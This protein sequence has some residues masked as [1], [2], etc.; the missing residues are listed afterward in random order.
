MVLPPARVRAGHLT[1]PRWLGR[2]LVDDDATLSVVAIG[3]T[4]LF[5]APCDLAASL[6]AQLKEAARRSE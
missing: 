1:F 5:G 2:R 3:S 6:G 4:V